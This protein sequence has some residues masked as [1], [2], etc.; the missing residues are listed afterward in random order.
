MELLFPFSFTFLISAVL[1]KIIINV[2]QSYRWLVRT[3][4]EDRWHKNDTP[5]MGGVAIFVAYS[6]TLLL[7][8]RFPAMWPTFEPGSLGMLWLGGFFIFLLGLID[9]FRPLPPY[10]KLIGQIS[11]ACLMVP[12]GIHI[13]LSLN[14]VIYTPITILWFIGITNAFNLL[15]NMDGLAGGI[16]LIAAASLCF[17]S[18]GTLPILISLT[19]MASIAGFL[20]FNINPARIFM[21]DCGSQWLGFTLAGLTLFDSWSN[22]K[23]LF[24]MIGT[25]VL[26]LAVPIFDTALVAVNRKLHGRSVSQGGKDHSS[27]RLVALGMSERKTVF[28]LWGIAIVFGLSASLT[29]YYQQETWLLPVGLFLIFA[30]VFGIFLTDVKV[31]GS[32]TKLKSDRKSGFF[33]FNLIYKRRIVEIMIDTISIGGAYV[34]AYMIRFDWNPDFFQRSLLYKSLPLVLAV[35]LIALFTMGL[36]RGLWTYIDFTGLARLLKACFLASATTVLTILLVYRFV[37]FSR[38]LFVID[39]GLLLFIMGGSRA[40]LRGLRETVFSFPEHGVRVLVI[41]A[42]EAARLLLNEIRRRRDWSIHPVAIL[43]DDVRKKGQ[44]L[45]G[46]RVVGTTDELEE[47]VKEFSIEQVILAIPSAQSQ[48][49]KALEARCAQLKLPISSM[50][51]IEES[52]VRR[53]G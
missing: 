19:I 35:K 36:Y 43:D 39:F 52:I 37:G 53:L 30:L 8:E 14:P 46:V 47:V 24:L 27:H 50:Q 23:N 12:F 13:K 38:T 44:R 26:I 5:S 45:L 49:K 25:P 40:M 33:N 4:T 15:D 32:K 48:K 51:S 10:V 41:G 18:G 20:I 31:Y 42:G 11:V 7:F 28:I 2:S 22:T 6:L 16:G 9:D 3:P 21:G 29:R 17:A 1:T 34:L